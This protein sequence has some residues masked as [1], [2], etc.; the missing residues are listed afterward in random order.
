M[1]SKLLTKAAIGKRQLPRISELL[2]VL[3]G[4]RDQLSC[5]DFCLCCL[6]GL[7]GKGIILTQ[8]ILEIF[9]LRKRVTNSLLFHY[10]VL[11]L[12]FFLNSSSNLE[13][14][15]GNQFPTNWPSRCAISFLVLLGFWFLFFFNIP[16]QF[17]QQILVKI[18][19][20]KIEVQ[21]LHE[22]DI[23]RAIAGPS[24]KVD[25][26]IPESIGLSTPSSVLTSTRLYDIDS[27]RRGKK[28]L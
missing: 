4:D 19:R 13:L 8:C 15:N 1:L 3:R 14:W 6:Y 25:L 27:S 9:S 11:A 24:A 20:A 7:R 2:I 12:L 17:C 18:Q 22:H 10:Y 28:R 26:D 5:S 21:Q 16:I 23:K